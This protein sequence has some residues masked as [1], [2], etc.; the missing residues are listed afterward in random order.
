MVPESPFES[1]VKKGFAKNLTLFLVNSEN[2]IVG[3]K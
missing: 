1:S 2:Q 3:E